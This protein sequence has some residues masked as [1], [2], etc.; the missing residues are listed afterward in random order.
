MM[1]TPIPQGVNINPQAGQ[2]G[3]QFALGVYDNQTRQYN[4]Q[5]DYLASTYASS[6][7]NSPLNWI[8][9]VGGLIPKFI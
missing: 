1:Q 6:Q 3:T 2:I 4:A 9:G 5:L 8:T 7:Q